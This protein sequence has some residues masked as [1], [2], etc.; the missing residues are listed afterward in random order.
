MAKLI[1]DIEFEGSPDIFVWRS[2]IEDFETGS[3]LTVKESQTALF[4]LN[5]ACVGELGAGRHILE[6]ENIPFLK[7]LFSRITGNKNI[8]HAQIYFINNA[9]MLSMK[10]GVGN[11]VYQDTS[12]IVFDIGCNGEINLT[13][14]NPRYIV[15]KVSGMQQSLSRDKLLEQFKGLITSEV[16][17]VLVNTIVEENIPIIN[18]S[19]HIRKI[20]EKVKPFIENIF[21]DYGF[22]VP[23]FRIIKIRLPEDDPQ[24]KRLKSLKADQGL[25]MTELELKR[26]AELIR[27][28][29]KAQ[30]ELVGAQTKAQKVKLE[31][32]A[33][34]FK[35]Q[36]EGYTYQQERQF[37]VM[38][39]A[40][41]NTS[42]GS[43]AGMNSEFM[44]LGAG[45]GVMGV[46]GDMMKNN[47][48]NMTEAV[49]PSLNTSSQNMNE[50]IKCSNCGEEVPVNAKFCL[51]CG[52]KTDNIFLCPKCGKETPKGKFC[53][54]C[55]EKLEDEKHCKNC[56]KLLEKGAKFCLEC[57]TRAE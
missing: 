49:T 9:E 43:I 48:G 32:D 47:L 4:Y 18:V 38:Q 34:A 41:E 28:Q 23:Q 20:S 45:L 2:D 24:F 54:N 46:V 11:I 29:S 51:N 53:I 39:S 21:E 19:G 6:T 50:K 36:A 56:G 57:G 31:A 7:N 22:I 35:R 37:D 27:A 30:T 10:W 44:Q 3:V 14:S 12:G 17:D 52:S 5:G 55:G 16:T 42:S 15:E 33:M 25:L 8:F 1:S 26:Q 40:V 13:V